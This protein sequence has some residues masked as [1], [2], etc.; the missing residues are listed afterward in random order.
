MILTSAMPSSPVFS[1][2]SLY[3]I[4]LAAAVGII[5]RILLVSR[6]IAI[7]KYSNAVNTSMLGS[8]VGQ[9]RHA[10]STFVYPGMQVPHRKPP[11]PSPQ[12]APVSIPP[13]SSHARQSP[14]R[15]CLIAGP[16]R[17]SGRSSPVQAVEVSQL[18][19]WA[20]S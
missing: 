14:L 17:P 1:L 13:E 18:R 9:I 15:A 8:A 16:V 12:I 3:Q 20:R 10:L 19:I 7:V 2:S 11:R 5:V 4:C 6:N